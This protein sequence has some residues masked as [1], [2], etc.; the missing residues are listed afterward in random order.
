MT[1]SGSFVFNQHAVR[2]KRPVAF[3]GLRVRTRAAHSLSSEGADEHQQS[4]LRKVEVG[5]DG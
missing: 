3:F 1:G 5:Q 2:R 4:R